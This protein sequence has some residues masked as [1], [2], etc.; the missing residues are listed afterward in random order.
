MDDR[1]DLIA[2]IRHALDGRWD[3]AHRLVQR[4]EGATAARIHAELHRI[5]G[6]LDNAAYWYRRAGM[7]MPG[8]EPQAELRAVLETLT[9]DA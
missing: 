2:A 5:E 8:N 3:D 1:A 6:D 7:S 4:H 9:P